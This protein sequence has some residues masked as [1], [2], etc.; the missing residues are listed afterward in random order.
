[1]ASTCDTAEAVAALRATLEAL[2]DA[3]WHESFVP[4]SAAAF[5]VLPRPD[6]HKAWS[7]WAPVTTIA[8]P[9]RRL[10]TAGGTED[11]NVGMRSL[12]QVLVAWS[13]AL[14]L[15]SE[16]ADYAD[17]LT[18]ETQ[19]LARLRSADGSAT[20]TIELVRITREVA[21]FSESDLYLVTL[22]ELQLDHM[23]GTVVGN[24]P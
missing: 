2:V 20:G 23:T 18:F 8:S 3:S 7:V 13:Y 22:V 16:V 9:R 6:L 5:D 11:R 10:R 12:T 24:A 1:M 19:V 17:A 14:R 4:P 15:E 21:P